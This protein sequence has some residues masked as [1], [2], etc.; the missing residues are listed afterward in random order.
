[1]RACQKAAA[2]KKCSSECAEGDTQVAA[3]LQPSNL[4]PSSRQL[5]WSARAST[6]GATSGR[7]NPNDGAAVAA[8]GRPSALASRL[9]SSSRT[10]HEARRYSVTIVVRA[11]CAP[12]GSAP[13]G[14]RHLS[15][16]R[17]ARDHLKFREIEIPS[18]E[19]MRRQEALALD[20]WRLA[21]A[22]RPTPAKPFRM[23]SL[24]LWRQQ[25]PGLWSRVR[26]RRSF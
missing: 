10:S 21:P 12:L 22:A 23:E 9:A 16:I 24:D 20:W 3:I 8:L 6:R 11:Q 25:L 14:G 13:T 17:G 7:V 19:D 5:P 4:S 26:G 15:P 18:S 1:M 2:N